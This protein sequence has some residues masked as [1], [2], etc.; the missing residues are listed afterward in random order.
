MQITFIGKVKEQ[1]QISAGDGKKQ[2]FLTLQVA[3][4]R[5]KG[6]NDQWVDKITEVPIFA[7]DKQAETI[8]QFVVQGQELRI[9]CSYVNTPENWG[10]WKLK[11]NFIKLGYKP[12]SSQTKTGTNIPV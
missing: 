8:E 4:E 7:T 11:A 3:T 2:A 6:A 12:K 5:V 10:H 9:D 1:P